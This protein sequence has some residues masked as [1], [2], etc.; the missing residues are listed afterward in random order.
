MVTNA[1]T[2]FPVYIISVVFP[3]PEWSGWGY[4]WKKISQIKSHVMYF[5]EQQGEAGS[6][7]NGIQLYYGIPYGHIGRNFGNISTLHN[8]APNV[9][10]IGGN[11]EKT[12]YT[13]LINPSWKGW[14]GYP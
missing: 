1:N 12:K 4:P 14:E 2:E 10:F 13:D 6:F 8:K 3:Y 9:L 5:S 11:V 7:Y